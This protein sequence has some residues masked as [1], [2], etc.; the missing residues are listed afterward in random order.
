M[1]RRKAFPHV[2]CCAS[3]VALSLAGCS[4]HASKLKSETNIT[5]NVPAESISSAENVRTPHATSTKST[6]GKKTPGSS[7]AS[8]YDNLWDR[9]FALYGLPRVDHQDVDRELEWFINHPTYIDRVQSR[10]EP[11]LYSIVRQVEKHEIPG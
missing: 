8:A 10:A 6:H 3:I 9:L 2:L 7:K 5:E 4:H 11:F 1:S